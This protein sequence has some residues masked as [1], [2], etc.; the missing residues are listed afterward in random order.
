MKVLLTGA[1]GR[2]GSAVCRYLHQSGVMLRATDRVPNRDLPVKIEL[3]DL[4]NPLDCHRMVD[5]MDALVHLA[6]HPWS[7][8]G[9]HQKVF[10]ENVQMNTQMFAAARDA[11]VQRIIFASSI[12]AMTG[13][14]HET[15]RFTLPAQLP[16]CGQT[17]AVP[18]NSYGMSKHVSERLLQF[19]TASGPMSGIALR[20]PGMHTD[21]ESQERIERSLK[22]YRDYQSL[23]PTVVFRLTHTQASQV[24]LAGLQ[25]NIT[26]YR[27]YF[28]AVIPPEL[29]PLT[30]IIMEKYW[31]TVPHRNPTARGEAAMVDRSDIE[32]D[33]G[34]VP[35]PLTLTP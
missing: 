27:C 3:A 30:S 31:N 15:D 2:V 35:Q 14:Q 5:G 29:E 1:A 26:G 16:L 34:W 8:P 18:G 32:K 25:S 24:I 9:K 6:N 13:Y 22:H 7:D 28:P 20:L 4:L 10:S 21:Q 11:G 23:Y 12:N 33:L 19:M 17:P